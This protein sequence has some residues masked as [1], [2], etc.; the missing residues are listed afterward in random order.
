VFVEVD[1]LRVNI[2]LSGT[3]PPLLLLH[4]WGGSSRSFAPILP[5]LVPS[6]SV[7]VPDLPGF[8]FSSLPPRV[9]GISDYAQFTLRLLERVGWQRAHL[10]GHSHGGRVSIAVA[11]QTPDVVDRLILVDSAGIRPPRTRALRLRGLVARNARRV[12]SHR[13]AGAR[14]ARYLDAL[15]RQLGMSD[16]ASAGP[17][18]ATFVRI[19]NEDLTQLLPRIAAPTLVVWGAD[20]NET[21]LW[22]G[23]QMA[24]DIPNATLMVLANA[25]HFS[26]I[27]ARGEFEQQAL[28]FLSAGQGQ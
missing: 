1:G 6:F 22:M 27:D 5:A 2:E 21:P 20:D 3:G 15:Y 12:L 14:G 26:Y 19:V 13:L 7:C 23:R 16:Y 4:G 11:A 8:G 17:L 24:I 28:N 9:W 18:R 25:G 10:L